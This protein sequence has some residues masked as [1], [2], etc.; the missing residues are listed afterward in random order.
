MPGLEMNT[1][2][3]LPK[4][5][6][7]LAV[8]SLPLTLLVRCLA[9]APCE[10]GD[11][12]APASHWGSWWTQVSPGPEQLGGTTPSSQAVPDIFPDPA[13]GFWPGCLPGLSSALWPSM[14]WQLEFEE[15]IL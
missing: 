3:R 5:N 13:G 1:E 12:P 6:S 4:I 8:F 7:L 9:A 11:A 2:P 10:L 15:I 14:A